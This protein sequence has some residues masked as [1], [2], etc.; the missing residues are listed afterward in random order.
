MSFEIL[1]GLSF[2]RD[3]T[4]LERH[5][6]DTS[7]NPDYPQKRIQQIRDKLDVLEDF[8]EIGIDRSDLLEGIRTYIVDSKCLV[9]YVVRAK[10]EQVVL[11]RVFY[12]GQDYEAMLTKWEDGA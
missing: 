4:A 11:L 12:S 8:P 2:L 7:D 6:A 5:L 3:L 10:H 9:A 1:E